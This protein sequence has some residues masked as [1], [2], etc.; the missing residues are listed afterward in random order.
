MR[1]FTKY[2]DLEFPHFF[3]WLINKVHRKWH[4]IGFV[5]QN[6]KI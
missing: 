1:G 4:V 5:C 3:N 2:G 6:K